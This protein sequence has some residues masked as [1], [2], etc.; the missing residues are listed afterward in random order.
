MKLSQRL[1]KHSLFDNLPLRSIDAIKKI[2]SVSRN[3]RTNTKFGYSNGQFVELAAVTSNTAIDVE[4][5]EMEGSTT[6]YGMLT[7]INGVNPP[8]A[9]LTLLN[10]T[11]LVCNVTEKNN[12]YVARQ[13]GKRLYS[14]IGVKGLARWDLRDMSL[15]FFRIDEMLDY[16]AKPVAEALDNLYS[17]AGQ[18]FEAIDD[19]EALSPI[20]AAVMGCSRWRYYASIR[21]FCFGH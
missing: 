16:E 11:K 8:S 21:K 1:S 20:C 13:L 10:G 6:L 5:P 17:L 12:L 9:H 15:T 19:V 3:Y 14:E 18:H 2:R 4:I 7:G